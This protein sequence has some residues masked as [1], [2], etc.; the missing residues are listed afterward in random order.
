MA[1]DITQRLANGYGFFVCDYAGGISGFAAY[2]QFRGGVGYAKTME[3]TIIIDPAAHGRGVGRL[4]M[5][6]LCDF[7]R[8]QGVMSLFAGVS[9]TNHVGL[10]FHRSLGF[11]DVAALQKVGFKF[12]RYLDLVLLQ[13][14]L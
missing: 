12:D 10:A 4:L 7:A 3:H 5:T 14:F 8:D 2:S 1:D 9:A 6:T 13:K 11:A